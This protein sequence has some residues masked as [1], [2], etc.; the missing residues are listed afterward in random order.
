MHIVA[1]IGNSRMKWG[2]AAPSGINRMAAVA[3][4]DPDAWRTQLSAWKSGG[5]CSWTLAGSHPTRRDRFAD[6]LRQRGN[7]VQVLAHYSQIPIEV[8]LP[9][10]DRVGIDRL[11]NALAARAIVPA[12]SP[13]IVV[14]AGSAVTVDLLDDTGAFAG[15]AI[16]PGF[17]L[18]AQSLHDHTAVLPV[19]EPP[20]MAPPVPGRDTEAAIQAGVFWAVAGGIA[21]LAKATALIA[22]SI[23]PTRVIVTGGDASRF[24]FCDFLDRSQFQVEFQPSLTLEGIRL[25]ST[26]RF[27]NS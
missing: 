7:M 25:A 11:V 24:E 9:Q 16:F 5:N 2:E 26:H 22:P 3:S 6:W 15:G 1:D 10:P 17:R 21:A 8:K 27:T 4:E 12:G 14:D 23:D 18:M 20:S 13:A 19:V